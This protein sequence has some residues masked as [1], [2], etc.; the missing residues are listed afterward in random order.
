[1]KPAA[2]E[3]QSAARR[4]RACHLSDGRYGCELANLVEVEGIELYLCTFHEKRLR[5]IVA[6]NLKH[7][8]TLKRAAA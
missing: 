8:K 4:G 2:T 7:K 3:K 5:Q 6:D 1:M